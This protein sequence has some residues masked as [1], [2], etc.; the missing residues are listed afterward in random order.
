[1]CLI[2]HFLI[3]AYREVSALVI[4]TKEKSGA[5]ILLTN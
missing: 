1:M 5:K 3:R 2:S 4:P